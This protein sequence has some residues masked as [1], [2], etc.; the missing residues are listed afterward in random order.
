MGK[1]VKN[2]ICKID[3]STSSGEKCLVEL[4]VNT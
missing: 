2:A 4:P 3:F 1:F